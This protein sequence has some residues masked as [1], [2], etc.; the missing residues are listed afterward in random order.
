MAT[1]GQT[2]NYRS[3]ECLNVIIRETRQPYDLLK[4]MQV[5]H[6]L[7]TCFAVFPDVLGCYRTVAKE[8]KTMKWS[9]A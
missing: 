7:L 5:R 3:S 4:F 2:P 8:I 9:A 1:T 6:F